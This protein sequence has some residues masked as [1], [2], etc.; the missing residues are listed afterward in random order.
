[1]TTATT[2]K[3]SEIMSNDVKSTIMDNV[4]FRLV[5]SDGANKTMSASEVGVLF[6]RDFVDSIFANGSASNGMGAFYVNKATAAGGK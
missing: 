5:A 2:T 6:G 4:T 1:M 3:R